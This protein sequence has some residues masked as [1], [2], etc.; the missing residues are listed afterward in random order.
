MT[1]YTKEWSA[2]VLEFVRKQLGEIVVPAG[3]TAATA[4]R[5][6]P[7]L[8]AKAQGKT[9]LADPEQRNAWTKRYSYT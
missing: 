6:K 4:S 5:T 7:A 8:S 2:V 3:E 1:T 9:V